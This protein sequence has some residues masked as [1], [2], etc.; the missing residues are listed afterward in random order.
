ML[1]YSAGELAVIYEICF[2]IKLHYAPLVQKE[3]NLTTPKIGVPLST[4]IVLCTGV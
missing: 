1:S 3:Q 2:S 4:G